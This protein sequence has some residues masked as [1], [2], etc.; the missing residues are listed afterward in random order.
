MSKIFSLQSKKT[1][2]YPNLYSIIMAEKRDDHKGIP[3]LPPTRNIEILPFL[4][5]EFGLVSQL[6]DFSKLGRMAG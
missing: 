2:L 6:K 3:L 4:G 5:T 1:V